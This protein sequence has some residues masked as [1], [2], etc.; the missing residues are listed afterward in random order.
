M[1]P[2]V[3][4]I[5]GNLGNRLDLIQRARI[6]LQE[7]IGIPILISSIFEAAPWGSVSSMNYL[8]QVLVFETSLNP[9]RLLTIGNQ[10][11]DQLGRTRIEKWGDRTMDI[12][13]LYI[14]NQVINS[15]KLIIPHPLILERKFVLAPLA[16]IMPDFLHPVHKLTNKEM[17]EIC[18]D[19]SSVVVLSDQ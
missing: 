14:G 17:L 4:I 16:E 18:E 2:V 15:A 12:D 3:F 6:S 13:I 5:G 9:E 1:E 19:I 8:N 11:E 7:I 10:I